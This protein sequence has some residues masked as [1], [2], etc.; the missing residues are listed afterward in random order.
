MEHGISLYIMSLLVALINLLFQLLYAQ[1]LY[2]TLKYFYYSIFSLP[3]LRLLKRC[4]IVNLNKE[5]CTIVFNFI[6]RIVLI[7]L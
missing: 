6:W 5:T 3:V 2:G 7:N 1:L 4:V